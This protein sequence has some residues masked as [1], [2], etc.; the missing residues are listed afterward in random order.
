MRTE[1]QTESM[2]NY[3]MV[4]ET[5]KPSFSKIVKISSGMALFGIFIILSF[6]NTI[7]AGTVF[8]LVGL[9][10]FGIWL[11]PY[12]D[13]NN[14]KTKPSEDQMNNWLIKDLNHEIKETAIKKLSLNINTLEQK[15]F[16]IVPYPVNW[17]EPGLNE[18]DILQRTT[19]NGNISYSVWNVQV[20][21]LTKNYISY[22]SCTYDW[23]NNFIVNERTNEFFYDDIS[24]VKNEQRTIGRYLKDKEYFTDSGQKSS[25]DQLTATVF[26]V[27]NI[28][29]DSLQVITNI[30]EMGH[31]PNLSVDLEKAVQVLRMILR[32]RR[33]NEEGPIII[34]K[35][36]EDK[37][38]EGNL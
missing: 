30:E 13:S 32:K 4:Q 14:I 1:N 27:T 9:T 37:N 5:W 15:N 21:A 25:P 22:Y 23:L 26:E 33:Y 2:Q 8:I 19:E 3:F 29:S 28:S 17:E 7:L 20:I 35:E 34:E 11:K 31:S 10:L 24:S 16:I 6:N 36:D 38:D 12:F 18:A